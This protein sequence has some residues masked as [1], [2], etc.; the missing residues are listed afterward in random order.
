VLLSN[1]HHQNDKLGL[2]KFDEFPLPEP[3]L[4]KD[5]FAFLS[6]TDLASMWDAPAAAIDDNEYTDDDE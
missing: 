2:N 5:P 4:D 1:Q 6:P 3:P